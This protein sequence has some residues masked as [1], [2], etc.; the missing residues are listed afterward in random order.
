MQFANF[1]LWWP[2]A[3]NSLVWLLF[4]FILSQKETNDLVFW[5]KEIYGQ[6]N[7]AKLTNFLVKSENNFREFENLKSAKFFYLKFKWYF[8]SFWIQGLVWYLRGNKFLGYLVSRYETSNI[9]RLF[10]FAIFCFSLFVCFFFIFQRYL[11]SRF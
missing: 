11:V 10:C 6:N 4:Y 9:L 5:C 8:V 7:A 2:I 1:T 3:Q